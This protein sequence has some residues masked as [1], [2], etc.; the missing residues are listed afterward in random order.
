MKS[1]RLIACLFVGALFGVGG[2]AW[3]R[4]GGEPSESKAKIA[5]EEKEACASESGEACNCSTGLNRASLLKSNREATE[6][7]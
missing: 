3:S 5:A 6:E 4:S 1:S 2:V 7:K